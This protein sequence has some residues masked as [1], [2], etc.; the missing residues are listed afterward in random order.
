MRRLS[1][2]RAMQLF[3]NGCWRQDGRPRQRGATQIVMAAN[4]TATTSSAIGATRPRE[5]RPG[6]KCW[7]QKSRHNSHLVERRDQA[8]LA[9]HVCQLVVRHV[10]DLNAKERHARKQIECAA[11]VLEGMLGWQ[12]MEEKE[13]ASRTST[14]HD[15][16]KR[17]SEHHTRREPEKKP[18]SQQSLMR[19]I[20]L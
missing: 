4:S 8:Q 6:T 9:R 12:F 13:A 11:L 1:S 15:K 10:Q 3:K 17:R 19:S 5:E 14:T 16:A 7:A 18:K 2:D 20:Y